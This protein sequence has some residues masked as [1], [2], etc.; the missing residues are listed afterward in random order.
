MDQSMTSS[1]IGFT[2]IAFLL[3]LGTAGG[4]Q[5]PSSLAQGEPP[6][7]RPVTPDPADWERRIGDLYENRGLARVERI[8]QL[9]MITTF[10]N[11]AHSTYIEPS[12]IDPAPYA[13]GYVTAQYRYVDRENPDARCVQAPCG[14]ITERRVVLERLERIEATAAQAQAAT[15]SCQSVTRQAVL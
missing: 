6:V 14:P 3:A 1:S 15:A 4:A 11:G 7:A 9:W 8:G 10:C 12:R 2:T 13:K 5:Q